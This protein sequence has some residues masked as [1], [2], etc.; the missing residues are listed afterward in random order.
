MSIASTRTH[1]RVVR[2]G[3]RCQ[4]SGSPPVLFINV[5]GPLPVST[6]D[7]RLNAKKSVVHTFTPQ[8][9]ASV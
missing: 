3:V 5:S 9:A 2:W 8:V 7:G 1:E 6:S 4:V